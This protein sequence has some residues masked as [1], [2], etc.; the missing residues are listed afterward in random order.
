MRDQHLPIKPRSRRQHMRYLPQS[1]QQR[2]PIPY[3]ISRHAH[4]VHMRSRPH[5]PLLQIPSH[6]I[7]NRQSNNQRSHPRRHPNHRDS[8]DHSNDSLPPLRPQIPRRNKKFKSH[9]T[10]SLLSANTDLRAA[11]QIVFLS[12]P[13]SPSDTP[14]K[15]SFRPKRVARSGEICFSTHTISQP[16]QALAFA[17]LVVIPEGDPLLLS[18]LFATPYSLN[19]TPCFNAPSPSADSNAAKPPPSAAQSKPPHPDS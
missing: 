3:P 8:G 17:S 10:T 4:Q 13:V 5:Q 18:F 15:T 19:P 1:L 7:R 11:L 16:R 14:P 9:R 6:P 2:P 12:L